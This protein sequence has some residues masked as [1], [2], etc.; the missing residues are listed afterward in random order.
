MPIGSVYRFF[1]D[2]RTVV[3]ALVQR[4][5]EA[6]LARVDR[7][8]EERHCGRWWDADLH[9]LD[10]ERD[11]GEVLAG[12]I[13]ELLAARFGLAGDPRLGR[14]MTVAVTIAGALLKRAF[15]LHPQG[16]RAGIGE[17]KLAVRLYLA[18]V[19][20]AAPET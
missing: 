2:K 14:A 10:A 1:L 12:R 3:H 11:S 6:F 7:L 9:L 17:A 16:G 8:F 18:R 19:L 5:L 13:G 15:R 20:S 4:Y